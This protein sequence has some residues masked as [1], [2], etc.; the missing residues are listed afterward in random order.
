MAHRAGYSA[1]AA[2]CFDLYYHRP[3]LRLAC[4][5]DGTSASGHRL[6]RKCQCPLLCGLAHT[7]VWLTRW[8]NCYAVLLGTADVK[9]CIACLVFVISHAAKHGVD[10][11]TLS[12]ELQQLGL[13]KGPSSPLPSRP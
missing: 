11:D 5:T 4:A 6:Q 10:G 2:G 7:S 12:R 9:A 8:L 13:P 3:K 1:A